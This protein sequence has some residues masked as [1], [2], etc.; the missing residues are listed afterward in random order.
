MMVSS[1]VRQ[2]EPARE[3]C[4]AFAPSTARTPGDV[5]PRIADFECRTTFLV[6]ARH[7]VAVHRG[8]GC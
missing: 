4:N 7:I 2:P 6:T 3:L 5:R 1:A 8:N